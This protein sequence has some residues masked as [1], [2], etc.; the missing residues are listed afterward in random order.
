MQVQKVGGAKVGS[1]ASSRELPKYLGPSVNPQR[2]FGLP[3]P[4]KHTSS[5]FYHCCTSQSAHD[6]LS[7][8]RV[9]TLNDILQ[10]V[11]YI[12]IGCYHES[13]KTLTH[14]V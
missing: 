12:Q 5:G 8:A 6:C 10:E 3:I 4:V 9:F 7:T 11:L 2:P 1:R 13:G 14:G